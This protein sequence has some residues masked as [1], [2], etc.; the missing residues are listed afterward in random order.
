MRFP[1]VVGLSIATR[2]DC[3]ADETLDLLCDLSKQTYLWLEIGLES[4]YDRTLA[5]VN[6][7][8]GLR[9]FIDA[10]ERA[11]ARELQALYPPHSRLSR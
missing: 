9:E 6:R 8:H 2:P 3:L 1:G 11:K 10:V 7:G 5:W 4:M